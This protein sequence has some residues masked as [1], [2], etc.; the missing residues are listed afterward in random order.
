M[1][2]LG[3]HCVACGKM[4]KKLMYHPETLAPY[5]VSPYICT[6]HHPNSVDQVLER[7]KEIKFIDLETAIREHKEKL[8]ENYNREEVERIRRLATQPQ[9][10]RLSDPEIAEFIVSIMKTESLSSV[11]EAVRYCVGIAMRQY[12]A[13]EEEEQPEPVPEHVPELKNDDDGDDFGT[14]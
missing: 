11:S 9:S 7:G 13:E 2:I 4:R 5:C 1:E 10:I 8:I 14:F 3:K 6:V 12:H